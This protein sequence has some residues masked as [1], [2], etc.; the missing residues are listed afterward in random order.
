MNG[1]TFQEEYGREIQL[2]RRARR[3][4]GVDEGVSLREI[5]R[6]W[7]KR[8]MET[9]PDRNPDDPDAQRKFRLVNCAYRLLTEG[10]PC[11]ELLTYGVEPERPPGHGK[12]DLG[13]AWGM[14]LWWRDK[15]F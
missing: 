15:F 5:K 3:V 10:R 2:R 13:N 7:R 4:I 11:N 9:H 14:F 6:A 8:C 12:Y 1:R